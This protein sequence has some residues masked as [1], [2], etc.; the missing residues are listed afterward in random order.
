M[1][2]CISSSLPQG[3]HEITKRMR[4]ISV[5]SARYQ[6]SH[7]IS[8]RSSKSSLVQLAKSSEIQTGT[9]QNLREALIL[10]S[11][12]EE[13]DAIS[14][15]NNVTGGNTINVEAAG[16]TARGAWHEQHQQ[17]GENNSCEKP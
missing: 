8:P 5:F 10:R 17:K 2:D 14:G 9:L 1:S 7:G 6:F 4:I 16:A 15:G 11:D 13:S 12:D 3:S